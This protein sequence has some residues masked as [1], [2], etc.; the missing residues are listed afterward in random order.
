MLREEIRSNQ[1]KE[2]RL[3]KRAERQAVK[4]LEGQAVLRP[5]RK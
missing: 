5:K 2:W 1:K 3:K 4:T